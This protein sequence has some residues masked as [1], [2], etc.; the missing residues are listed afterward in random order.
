M[1]FGAAQVVHMSIEEALVLARPV[2]YAA[3]LLPE[4][5]TVMVIFR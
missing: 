2:E 1:L 4:T 3:F 5:H